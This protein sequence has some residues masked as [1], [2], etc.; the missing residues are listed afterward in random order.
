MKK[1]F[2]ILMLFVITSCIKQEKPIYS[3]NES[4]NDFVV[5]NKSTLAD[6]SREQLVTLPIAYQRAILNSF[7]NEKK[8]SLW[9]EKLD[10][11]LL[12]NISDDYRAKI[13]E[14]RNFVN[15]EIYNHEMYEK[16]ED[17]VTNFIVNWEQN[18]L[19]RLEFDTVVFSINFCTLMTFDEYEY[20]VN[21]YDGIDYSWLEGGVDIIRLPLGQGTCTC[22]YDFYCSVFMN[23]E[24]E[25]GKNNCSPSWDCGVMGSSKCDGMCG[26]N[27]EPNQN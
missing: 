25:D 13:V 7:S 10:L 6:I 21:N 11:V 17:N 4:I 8:A 1:L 24:C 23:V 3:C 20:F 15:P 12:Q 26:E 16:P 22:R 18:V 5:T 2:Y 14:L 9:I 19:N 27:V